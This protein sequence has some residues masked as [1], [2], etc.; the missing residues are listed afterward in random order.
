[1]DVRVSTR[2]VQQFEG[3]ALAVGMFSDKGP[4]HGPAAALDEALAGVIAELRASGEVTGAADEVTLLHTL[5]KIEPSRVAIIGLGPR[6][7]CT[8]ERIRR[9][10]AIAC[11]R[12]RKVKARHIGLALASAERGINLAQAARAMTEG[13]LL[14]LYEFQQYKARGSRDNGEQDTE[15]DGGCSIQTI[16]ILGRGREPALRSAVERGKVLAEATNFARDL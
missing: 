3:D 16:T 11:R 9:A 12:L 15:S 4:L 13:A 14:G 1:M 7:R 5:G 8:L 6:D 2:D 10:S